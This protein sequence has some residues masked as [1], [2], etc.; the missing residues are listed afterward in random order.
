[1]IEGEAGVG[2]M[3]KSSGFVLPPLMFDEHEIEAVV[4]GMRWAVANADA[5]LA[6]AAKSALA[7]INAVLPESL[8]ELFK[9]QALYPI[10][11]NRTDYALTEQQVLSVI[12]AALRGN[13]ALILDYADAEGR[14]SRRTVWPVAMAYFEESRLLAA[15]CTLRQDFRHFRPDRMICAEIGE[16]YAIPR[17]VLLA[18]WQRS[19]C[20]DLHRFDFY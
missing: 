17:D 3:L 14:T 4:F 2:L 7:K 6:D 5:A 12:R 18:Q 8:S 9:Q 11:A 16:P 10:S 20:V 19:I 1:E 13:R 15:W